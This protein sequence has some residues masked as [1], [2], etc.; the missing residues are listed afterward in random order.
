MTRGRRLSG[1]LMLFGVL[2]LMALVPSASAAQSE[3]TVTID[4][5]DYGCLEAD[6]IEDDIFIEFTCSIPVNA[7]L[8]AKSDFYLTLTLPSGHAL[9][10]LVT[11]IGKYSEIRLRVH[12][13]NSAWESGWYNLKINAYNY[14]ADRG[15]CM[16]SYDFDPPKSG[17]GE[18]SIQVFVL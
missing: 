3:F 17:P 9:H 18:P 13:Y 10:A 7:R 8:A 4:R 12:W 2:T 6:G 5:A 1:I 15:H 16:S 14:G 11:V